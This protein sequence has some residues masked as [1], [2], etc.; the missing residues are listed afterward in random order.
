[1]RIRNYFLFILISIIFILPFSSCELFDELG[2]TEKQKVTRIFTE[3]SPWKLDT[4]V[5]KTDLMSGG[6]SVITSDT[7]YYNYGTIEFLDPANANNPG[8]NT[9]YMIH[10][11]T[12]NGSEMVDT[13]AWAPYNHNSGSDNHVTIFIRNSNSYDFVVGAWDMYL[14]KIIIDKK[15]VKIEG[16]RREDA[17]GTTGGTYGT[18]RSYVLTR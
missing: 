2:E 9:G 17:G 7:A 1:M 5:L 8:Y 3:G 4:L 12:R 11:Y 14:D 16:W 13:M 18:F 10:R 15:K 6:V